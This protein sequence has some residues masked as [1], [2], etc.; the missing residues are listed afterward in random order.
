MRTLRWIAMV[1]VTMVAATV[2]GGQALAG[3]GPRTTQVSGRFSGH[4][5][6]DD[7]TFCTGIDGQ[8][9]DDRGVSAGTVTSEDPR[10][11][12]DFVNHVRTLLNLDTGIGRAVG[13]IVVTDP[14][15]GEVK[16]RFTIYVAGQIQPDG[17]G[18]LKGMEIGTVSDGSVLFANS[19]T[20]TNPDGTFTGEFGGQPGPTDLA[21]IQGGN[22]R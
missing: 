8:Y 3:G 12:G 17:T 22:C 9:L 6:S 14:T 21:V 13:H 16:A 7:P 18:T 1:A 10:L 2:L 5:V 15:T 4:G 11:S 19:T 20:T